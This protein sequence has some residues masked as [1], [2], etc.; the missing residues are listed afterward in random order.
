MGHWDGKQLAE[1]KNELNRIKTEMAQE[2]A[3]DRV[4]PD[5]VPHRDQFP[6][7]LSD[8]NA[9][10]L[11]GCDGENCLCGA[12]ANRVEKVEDVRRFSLIDYH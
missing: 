3:N 6:A 1:L 5:G 12:G 9:Y 7:E 4:A 2:G 11:W 10:P 8:F